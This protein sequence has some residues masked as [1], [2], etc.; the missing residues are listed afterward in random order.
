M[1]DLAPA[2]ALDATTIRIER[3]MPAPIARVWDYLTDPA[4]RETW[5]AGGEFDLRRGGAVTLE[6]DHSRI[7]PEKEPPARFTAE[8]RAVVHG[9]IT[10]C[11]PPRVLA[12]SWRFMDEDSEVTFELTPDGEATR[13]VVTHRRLAGRTQK[14]MVASGWDAH[15]AILADRLA[16]RE[17]RG[18]WSMHAR[19]ETEYERCL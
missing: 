15:L 17:P 2:L 13:L 9:T 16:G 6:F 7:S 14:V 4:L 11:E 12:Y 5:F 18:F 10:R 1:N 3:R 8:S 19:L